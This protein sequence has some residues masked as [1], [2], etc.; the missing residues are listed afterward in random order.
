[1]KNP[2]Q[3]D[4]FDLVF[5]TRNFRRSLSYREFVTA[6]SIAVLVLAGHAI[7]YYFSDIEWVGNNNQMLRV[8]LILV[9]APVNHVFYKIEH[10]RQNN[11]IGRNLHDYIFLL[12]FIT[13]VK[14]YSW[15]NGNAISVGFGNFQSSVMAIIGLIILIILFET[16]VAF[17]KIILRY[18]RWRVL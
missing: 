12:C 18:F 4:F 6:L 13:V 3:P 10:K 9:L 14:F 2:Q 8:I 7:I 17:L 5:S 15:I 11:F 16:V 1:M